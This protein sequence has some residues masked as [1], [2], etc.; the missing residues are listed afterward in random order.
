MMQS[1]TLSLKIA[2]MVGEDDGKRGSYAGHH[3]E[4]IG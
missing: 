1:D 4:H 2:Y 3:K